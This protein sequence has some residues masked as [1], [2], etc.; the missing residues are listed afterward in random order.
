MDNYPD[1]IHQYDNNPNSPL[2]D[3]PDYPM[4]EHCNDH[5]QEVH[6]Q[7]QF[8]DACI[9][10]CTLYKISYKDDNGEA[11]YAE[12]Y[13]HCDEDTVLSDYAMRAGEEAWTELSFRMTR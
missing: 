6:E 2:Y 10:D 8:C 12:L 5:C 13:A 11:F 1:D 9:P 3:G 7:D 4:C